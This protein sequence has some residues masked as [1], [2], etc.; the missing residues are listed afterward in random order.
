MADRI[1]I[2]FNGMPTYPHAGKSR[3]RILEETESYIHFI[4]CLT[5]LLSSPSAELREAG[6]LYLKLARQRCVGT[7]EGRLDFNELVR[8]VREEGVVLTEEQFT[9][10][11]DAALT[12]PKPVA[13]P[14]NASGKTVEEEALSVEKARKYPKLMWLALICF[15]VSA[16]LAV[17]ARLKQS[18]GSGDPDPHQLPRPSLTYQLSRVPSK[19]DENR[20]C[21]VLL[22]DV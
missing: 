12:E 16:T 17:R 21:I 20:N 22:L 8:S 2:A 15:L 5:G 13:V 1:G 10:K 11:E 4:N 14:Q 18:E 6:H 9:A 3:E 19:Q 7:P